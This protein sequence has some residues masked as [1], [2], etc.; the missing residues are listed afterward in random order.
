MFLRQE[1]LF[2]SNEKKDI[3]TC[4]IRKIRHIGFNSINPTHNNAKRNI[5]GKEHDNDKHTVVA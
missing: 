2:R 3:R 1:H 4:S 5:L